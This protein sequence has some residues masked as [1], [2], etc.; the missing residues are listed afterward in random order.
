MSFFSVSLFRNRPIR[1]LCMLILVATVSTEN[2]SAADAPHPVIAGFER[3]YVDE[4]ADLVAGGRLLLGELNCVSCHQTGG[5]ATHKQAPILD[6][7]A[8]RVRADYL[9][10]FL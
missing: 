4:K 8:S 5:P 2:L 1:F 9:T 10:K 7:V 3:F 6:R